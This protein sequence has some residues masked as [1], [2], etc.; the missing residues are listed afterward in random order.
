MITWSLFF[1][2]LHFHHSH[3]PSFFWFDGDPFFWFDGVWVTSLDTHPPSNQSFTFL[4]SSTHALR[5]GYNSPFTQ[6]CKHSISLKWWF[7][8]IRF[9][10]RPHKR[11]KLL[12]KK[13]PVRGGGLGEMAGRKSLPRVCSLSLYNTGSKQRD[14]LSEDWCP[15]VSIFD[16]IY[17][18]LIGHIMAEG[19]NAWWPGSYFWY[20][21]STYTWWW[22]QVPE[23]L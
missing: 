9:P 11:K 15:D 22:Q 20:S 10:N 1:C 3:S 21:T 4:S 18:Y 6:R 19:W 17:C 16:L 2:I 5:K 23:G 14:A 13:A 7:M 12:Q 8:F